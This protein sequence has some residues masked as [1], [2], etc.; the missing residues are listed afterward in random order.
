MGADMTSAIYV[1]TRS[2][3]S[4]G[5]N[6]YLEVIYSGGSDSDAPT[7]S[8]VPYS[9]LT[10]YVEGERTFFTTLTDLSGIDTTSTNGVTMSYSVNNGSWTSV[11]ATTIQTCTSSASECRFK[12]TT[13]D[14]SAGDYVEYYW[15]FQD[16]NTAG[17]ANLGYDFAPPASN[18]APGTWVESNAHYFF[19]DDITNAGDA[20]KFTVL[21]TDVHSGSYYSP[22]GYHDRQMTYYDHSD[23]YLFEW[24]VSNCGTGSYSCFYSSSYYFYSQWKL[25]WTTTPSGGYNGYGGTQSGLD[26][27]HQGDGGYLAI[28]AKNGPQMNIIFHYDSGDNAWGMV[29]IGD[30][31][32]EIE[33]GALAGGS[34]A[35]SVSTYG[36][37]AAYNV[38][39]PGDITGTFG[40]ITWN[41]TGYSTSKANWLCVGTN[42]FYYF[43]RSSS[44]NA[45]CN[46]GYYYAYQTSSYKW[47]GVALS[48][49]YYGRMATSGSI[50]Y[51]VGKVAPTPDTM[52]PDM[53]HSVLRDSHS[54]SRTFT[55][56]IADAGDLLVGLNVN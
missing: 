35:S 10:S 37:T 56:T 32:P 11:S 44:S 12:A 39:I 25:Q 55:Y 50:T 13:A 34:Q 31:T 40:K 45:R 53:D 6:S 49:G 23:E 3:N 2:Y 16:L 52:A 20:K 43:Y 47:S 24:D 7:S 1:Y 30:S 42:G 19:V 41:G 5:S 28:S 27:L 38:P 14:I 22:Q 29:G 15:K 4:G 9:G 48:A 36:Y 18:S 26:E 54:K 51:K 46:T 21:T 8:H 17:G 33:T